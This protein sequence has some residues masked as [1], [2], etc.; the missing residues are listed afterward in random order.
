MYSLPPPL[1]IDLWSQAKRILAPIFRKFWAGIIS[2][3]PQ[4]VSKSSAD[5]EPKGVLPRPSGSTHVN[6]LLVVWEFVG[7]R[8]GSL[9]CAWN[10][11][12]TSP[13]GPTAISSQW[14]LVELGKL[15]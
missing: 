12:K 8:Y 13:P 11:A 6:T 14:Q 10:A 2:N 9:Y 7:V 3:Q 15:G 5:V 1:L 4:F